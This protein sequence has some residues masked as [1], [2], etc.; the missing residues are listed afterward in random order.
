[1]NFI[2][3][4]IIRWFILFSINTVSWQNWVNG[5][6]SNVSSGRMR[7]PSIDLGELNPVWKGQTQ[8][9]SGSRDMDLKKSFDL[10][11]HLWIKPVQLWP[12]W[13]IVTLFQWGY[14]LLGIPRWQHSYT[15]CLKV[16]VIWSNSTWFRILHKS[17]IFFLLKIWTFLAGSFVLKVRL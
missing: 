2:D 15:G 14:I 12:N 3:D 1:M 17:S 9:S 5:V 16:I 4:G 6:N 10:I 7:S 11:R 13:S 8:M